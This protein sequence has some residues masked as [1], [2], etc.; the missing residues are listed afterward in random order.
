MPNI[1]AEN[2]DTKNKISELGAMI[3]KCR[4]GKMNQSNLAS[5]AGIPRSN[6]KY[7]EDGRNAPTAIVYKRII[8]A[9]LPDAET[10]QKMDRLY[11]QIRK[12]PPPDI[13]EIFSSNPE[14]IEVFRSLKESNISAEQIMQMTGTAVAQAKP[15]KGENSNE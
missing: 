13:C 5:A 6:M 7:I 11:M 2:E 12:T 8:N 15:D 1:I 10:K 14:W 9:L 3:V 4:E